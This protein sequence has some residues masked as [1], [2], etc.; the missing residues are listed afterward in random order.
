M[1]LNGEFMPQAGAV[2]AMQHLE[3]TEVCQYIRWL[4]LIFLLIEA[5]NMMLGYFYHWPVFTGQVI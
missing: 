5:G 4:P 2:G 3:L 1:H